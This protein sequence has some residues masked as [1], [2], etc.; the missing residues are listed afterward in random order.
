MARLCAAMPVVSIDVPSGW[1]V[2][3]GDVLNIGLNPSLL[4]SLTAPKMCSTHFRGQFHI[5]GGRFVPP[6]IAEKYN[7]K[8]P[9]YPGRE[10][11]VELPRSTGDDTSN[12]RK[13]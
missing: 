9:S 12:E 4:V 3:N 5:V 10:Q 13:R 8:L 1:D 11:F 7:L 2:E 6:A